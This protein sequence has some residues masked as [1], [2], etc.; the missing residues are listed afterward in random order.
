MQS[1]TAKQFPPARV[2]ATDVGAGSGRR[3]LGLLL[4]GVLVVGLLALATYAD[5]QLAE[6]ETVAVTAEQEPVYLPDIRFLRLASLG[7][8]NTL[9]DVLWFR[10]INY[11]GKHFRGDR[12][13]PWLARMCEI[14][15]DLDP[16]AEHV[17]R[18]AGFILPW[19]AQ[20]PDEGIRLMEKG[21]EQFPDSWQLN[22]HLGFAKFYFNDDV[23]G[24][25]PHI[26]R[27]AG[28]P[29]AHPY[30]T[31]FAAMLYSQEYGSHTAREFLEELRDSGTAGG[32]EG[33]IDERLKDV[34]HTEHLAM[35]NNAVNE[36][37]N[38]SGR[39]PESLDAL[40]AAKLIDAVPS[41]PFGDRYIYDPQTHEAR[42][43]SGRPALKAYSSAKRQQVL[44]GKVYRD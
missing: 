36:Y 8:Q 22:Y 32:M 33:V 18:F 14:V 21:V 20:L 41:E 1:V 37:R 38:R 7:Y 35:L 17:Y 39:E 10:T 42:S 15:T 31:R 9:A 23:A 2:A 28:L 30:V 25:L 24:A 6:A 34:A 3:L 5:D 29:G 44:S 4:L 11:F 26:R 13:Y 43:S 12:L 19:E 40:V 27:A 16:H